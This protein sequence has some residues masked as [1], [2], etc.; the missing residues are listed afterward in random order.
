MKGPLK[1]NFRVASLP[2]T[3][4]VCEEGSLYATIFYDSLKPHGIDCVAELVP[5]E[6]WLKQHARS[7]DAIHIHWPEHIWRSRHLKWAHPLRDLRGYYWFRRATHWPRSFLGLRH[8]RPLLNCA[9]NYGLRIIWTIHDLTPHEKAG[10]IDHVGYRIL[11][12]Q[13]D[14]I[15]CHS[16]TARNTFISTYGFADKTLVMRHGNFATAYPAPRPREFVLQDL[17]LKQE[18]PLVCFLGLLRGY[19]GVDLCLDAIAKLGGR[20]QLVIAGAPHADFHVRAFSRR[21]SQMKNTVFIPKF[22]SAQEFADFASASEAFLLPYHRITTSGVLHAAFTFHRGVIASDI[23]FF[24]ECLSDNDNYGRLFRTGDAAAFAN[25]I[26]DYLR[27]PNKVRAEA[28]MEFAE[29]HRWDKVVL[30]VVEAIKKW[31]K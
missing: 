14:V 1:I 20:V 26:E 13:S 29:R 3:I 27:I 6:A 19:K 12:R 4:S 21:V 10:W 28:A 7:F 15:I 24:R 17:G 30:P 22:L 16:E 8:L 31:M 2:G 11:A 5:D 9:K 25:A 23:P 18:L